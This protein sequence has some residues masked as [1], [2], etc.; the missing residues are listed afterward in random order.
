MAKNSTDKVRMFLTGGDYSNDFRVNPYPIEDC[1]AD[2][3][4]Q[5][6]MNPGEVMFLVVPADKT[7]DQILELLESMKEA[8]EEGME[9]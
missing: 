3:E 1:A 7:K 5:W 6:I 4:H 8:V 9:E 2:I